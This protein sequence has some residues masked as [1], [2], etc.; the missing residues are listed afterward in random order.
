MSGP[1][2][3]LVIANPSDKQ[4]ADISWIQSIP[5]AAYDIVIQNEPLPTSAL[6]LKYVIDN[7][8][9][10]PDYAVFLQADPF[11]FITVSKER[12]MEIIATDPSILYDKTQWLQNLKANGQGYP[13]H[14][15]LRIAE[16]Y[17][18][19]FPGLKPPQVFEFNAGSQF[20]TTK[21]KVLAHPKAFYE[22]VLLFVES[23]ELCPF[24]IERLWPF[25]LLTPPQAQAQG[26]TGPA[27]TGNQM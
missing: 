19:L 10:F 18:K 20:M 5:S 23:K 22:T 11:P 8:E 3:A 7:Y 17:E 24:T 15:G 6:Y 14:P 4:A 9:S 26:A 21:A 16:W 2:V 27:P 1:K 12:F 25:I 13:H